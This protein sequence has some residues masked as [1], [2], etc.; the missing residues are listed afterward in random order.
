MQMT[1]IPAKVLIVDR[2]GDQ[3]LITVR[4]ETEKIGGTVDRLSFGKIN[5]LGRYVS[6]RLARSCLLSESRTQSREA[7]PSLEDSLA[8]VRHS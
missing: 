2:L 4:V 7:V 1:P 8:Y 6:Q 3:F 5:P